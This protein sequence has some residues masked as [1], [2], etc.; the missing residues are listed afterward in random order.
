MNEILLYDIEVFP[1]FFMTGLKNFKTKEIWYWEVSEYR[2]DRQEIY[3]FFNKYKGYLVS[4]NGIYYDNVVVSFFLKEYKKLK[5]LS[6]SDF[7]DQ[8][9]KCSNAVIDRENNYDKLKSYIWYEN[10]WKDIDLFLYW[11]KGLRI[12]KKIS[13][14]GLGI[15]LGYHTV[16]ELPYHPDL[17]LNRSQM[18]D[19]I[20]YNTK[21]DLGILELLTQEM[22]QD[23]NLRFFVKKEYGLNCLSMDAPKIASEVL[24]K[25]FCDKT[26]QEPVEVRKWR[27]EPYYGLIDK[28]LEDVSFSFKNKQ[29]QE[30]YERIL[31]SDRKFS[32]EF[33]FISGETSLNISLGIGGIHSLVENK[34]YESKGDTI[35]VSSDVASLYPA[36][37][38]NYDICRFPEVMQLYSEIR[39]QRLISKKKK[40]KQKDTFLKLVLN[41]FSGLIDN[42][43]SWLY[44]P[45]GAL[46]LRI[47]GQLLMLKA[48]DECVDK[49]YKV[50]ALN[51][52]SI[53]VEIGKKDLQNYT[54]I[55]DNVGKDYRV[56]FEHENIQ[57]T[58][59]L[60]INNYI[61]LSAEGKVKRK[62][63]FKL[64]YNEKGDREIPL[65]DSVNEL[66]VPKALSLYFVNGVDIEESISHPKD[67]NFHIFNY[68]ASKKVNRDY[69]V[70]YNG[71]QQ[72][73]LNRY[74]AAN[75]APYLF[76]KK[77]GKDTME[78]ISKD[79]PV[80]IYNN[81]KED[82]YKINYQYYINKAR[83]IIRALEPLQLQLF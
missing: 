55:I 8:I 70:W 32:E 38:I 11:S 68:C 67:Y 6:V 82:Q 71:Q 10:S 26:G 60:N 18:D 42:E 69:T 34:C 51:T 63:M 14:K 59:F 49:G 35:L 31:K 80:I 62:G 39:D 17:V 46:K 12:S 13:L 74:Y 83:N 43:Y 21:H 23:I 41:S 72:Q 37:I 44:F 75:P 40:E 25:A 36:N 79:T 29:L 48:L 7:L 76:K 53:D 52:D 54:D 20:E 78:H 30:V 16:Q 5:T 45:E 2:D 4:F 24:L 56:I 66:V 57:W 3:K 47:I 81:H 15:Q 64:D 61:Q 9:K 58:K 19:I 33:V 73:N 50:I 77:K 22:Q 27:Y 28:L 1:G 65:G